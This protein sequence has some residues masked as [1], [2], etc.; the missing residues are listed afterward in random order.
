MAKRNQL[1]ELRNLLVGPEQEV[2]EDL[3]R[4]VHEPEVRATDIADVLPDSLSRSHESGDA[5]T[6]SLKDPVEACLQQSFKEK[7]QEYADALYPIM[8]PA[9]RKSIT[10]TLRS[11]VQTINQA[12]ENSL[13]PKGLQWR[14]Q[15]W[16]AGVPFGQYVLQQ[17]LRYRVE[18]AYLIQKGTGLLVAEVSDESA[19]LNRDKDAVSAMFSAIQDF[20]RESFAESDDSRLQ[21]ADMGEF[22]VWAIH[23]AHTILACVIRGVPPRSLREDMAEIL[24]GIHLTHSDTLKNFSG[25]KTGVS[26]LE[27]PLS[28]CLVFENTTDEPEGDKRKISPMLLVMLLVVLGLLCYWAFN[29]WITKRQLSRLQT[30]LTD[31]PGI[32]LTDA[33]ARGSRFLLSGLRDPLARDVSEIV[34]GVDIEPSRV[35][36]QFRPYQS[37]EQTFVMRRLQQVVGDSEV[38]LELQAGGLIVDGALSAEVRQQLQTLAPTYGLHSI[39]FSVDDD[40]LLQ[41][42]IEA[43]KPPTG[44]QVRVSEG[45]AVFSGSASL[46][47]LRATRPVAQGMQGLAS[48][49][50]DELQ[51]QEEQEFDRLLTELEMQEF[52]FSRAVALD[53]GET[54]RL[55]SYAD[56][57]QRLHT[58]GVQLNRTVVF[59]IVGHTDRA[60]A[61]AANERLALARATVAEQAL[62][63][64]LPDGA[65]IRLS[66][67]VPSVG[68]EGQRKVSIAA[69]YE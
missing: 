65:D 17:R 6:R 59:S 23:G 8:G 48:V 21:T 16:R 13:T 11:L 26:Y 62:Q 50:F 2:L 64:K 51:I 47:W 54:A 25:D 4:R 60:G 24:E 37:L 34:A 49:S 55:L 18:Q 58:L 35:N 38:K 63:G 22:T 67:N 29:A 3:S 53:R 57:A 33:E 42:V 56:S 7:P 9:I 27:E 28:K 14:W 40:V 1:E 36:I 39:E 66:T 20:V 15:A 45:S 12:V 46:G 52:F 31:E 68:N 69:V 5:L 19:Q 32:V 30:V 61:R 43:T 44:V 10:E 41:R